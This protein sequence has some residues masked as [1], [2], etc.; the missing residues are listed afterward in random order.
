[1]AYERALE[2]GAQPGRSQRRPDGTEH[3]RDQG[4]RRRAALSGR[5]LRR[6]QSIYDVD[7]ASDRAAP[8]RSRARPG[9]T[10][11]RPPDPQRVPRPHGVWAGFYEKLFNF[12]EIRY[13]DIEGE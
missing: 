3:A 4:H 13:F 12:R 11:H 6:A 8:A 7:F 1:M 9:L 10:L 5:P 2:L